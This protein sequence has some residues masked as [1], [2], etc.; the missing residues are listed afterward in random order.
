MSVITNKL[1]K[2]REHR[3]KLKKAWA[4]V[5]QIKV[6]RNTVSILKSKKYSLAH[7]EGK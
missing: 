1:N 5:K 2:R 4:K 6:I 7:G 3:K